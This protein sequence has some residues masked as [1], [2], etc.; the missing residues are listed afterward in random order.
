[1]LGVAQGVQLPTRQ[2]GTQGWDRRLHSNARLVHVLV[3]L[4]PQQRR[5]IIWGRFLLH[6]AVR[7]L[8]GVWVDQAAAVHLRKIA[9]KI[10]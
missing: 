8:E 6:K 10:H 2:L 1:M 7:E 9:V 5:V 4:L 3:H